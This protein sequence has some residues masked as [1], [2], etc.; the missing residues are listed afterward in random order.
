MGA[1]AGNNDNTAMKKGGAQLAGPLFKKVITK[2]LQKVGDESFPVIPVPDLGGA[3]ILRGLWQGGESFFIDSISG[4]LATDF[5]P[6]ESRVEKV[7]TN[8]HSILYWVDK[9]D[10]TGPS[11]K[12]PENDPQFKNWEYGVRNWANRNYI[13]T[14]DSSS[15]P[16]YQ[17]N[18]HQSIM[19]IPITMTGIDDGAEIREGE[20]IKITLSMDSVTIKNIDIYIDSRKITTLTM[21]PWEYEIDLKPLKLKAGSHIIKAIAYDTLLYRGEDVLSFNYIPEEVTSSLEIPE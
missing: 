11:P 12:N 8:V 14:I 5:T 9:D 18:I 7:L 19:T 2:H 15:I 16:G 10:P 3:P 4:G 1:W 6:Q 21:A 13:P 17:D 20:K